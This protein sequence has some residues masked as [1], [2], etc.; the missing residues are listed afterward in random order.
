MGI[1]QAWHM[2]DLLGD[3]EKK[4]FKYLYSLVKERG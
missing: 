4:A 2:V 1:A 3:D